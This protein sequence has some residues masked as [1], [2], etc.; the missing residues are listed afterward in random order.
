[1]VEIKLLV[2]IKMDL[3]LNNL[4]WLICHKTKPN[5]TKPIM[6]FCSGG[7][8]KKPK[9]FVSSLIGSDSGAAPPLFHINRGKKYSD[10]CVVLNDFPIVYKF[11]KPCLLNVGLA[12]ITWVL[13]GVMVNVLDCDCIVS[14][15]ELQSRYYVH[16]RT[17]APWRRYEASKHSSSPRRQLGIK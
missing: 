12:T 17:N 4:Q 8:R 16:F 10:L 5:Q 9:Q 11:R 3:V 14:E 6:F 7:T 15:F 13:D 2:C 1:M